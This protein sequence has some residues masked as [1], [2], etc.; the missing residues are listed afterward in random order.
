MA[1]RRIMLLA[2]AAALAGSGPVGAQSSRCRVMD[3]TGIP[4]N[5]RAGPGG[6]V[7]GQL[8]NGMLVRAAQSVRDPN[9]RTWTFVYGRDGEPI[10]W[11]F[12]EFIACF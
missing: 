10:G 1:M 3:P 11:V 5:V 12:R 6:S 8:P 4:L 7:V 2:A 9:G